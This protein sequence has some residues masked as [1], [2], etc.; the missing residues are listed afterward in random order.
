GVKQRRLQMDLAEDVPVAGRRQRVRKQAAVGEDL[1]VGLQRGGHYP[2]D[3]PERGD[4][5]ESEEAVVGAGRDRSLH[6]AR[7]DHSS[8]SPIRN[9][10]FI[11]TIRT[12]PVTTMKTPTAFA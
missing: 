2:E 5:D 4:G 8:R 6:E 7:R 3:W 10:F 12:N 1:R 9:N 11:A